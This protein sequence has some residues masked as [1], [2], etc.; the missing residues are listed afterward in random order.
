MQDLQILLQS[1][2][3]WLL[4][5][6]VLVEQAGLLSKVCKLSL[7]EDSCI[8]Q[9]QKLFL[10]I[11]ARAAG[12]QVPARRG[13]SQHLGAGGRL[14]RLGARGAEFR[15]ITNSTELV[16]RILVLGAGG[17]GGFFGGRAAQA[18]VDV[19]FLL[20]PARAELVRAAGLRIKTGDQVETV[21]PKVV[22]AD[23]PGG[24]YDVVIL[25]CK[26]YDL[27][28]AIESLKPVVGK[29]T[30]ILPILN[31]MRHYDMLDRAFGKERVLGGLCQVT[32]TIGPEGEILVMG[33][34]STIIFGEREGG[35]SPRGGAIQK[36]LAPA[37][38]TTKC[39]DDIF[40][41][42][43]EKYVFL[44]ALA[45]AT[46]LMRGNVGE[47]ARTDDGEHFMRSL[48]METNSVARGHGHGMRPNAEA[49]AIKAL[50][51]ASS[52]VT[53]SMFRDLRQGHRIEG[54][55]LIGDM[56]HRAGELGLAVPCLRTAYTHLQV[57][58]AQRAA[59]QA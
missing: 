8:R 16:M 43:W 23:A 41:D 26:A 5:L 21:H 54:E 45:A 57:Y 39:S 51:D 28:S 46:C 42:I 34:F 30:V 49:F 35:I 50:T 37:A 7:S 52:S 53:A 4:F 14:R 29:D 32:A 33:P 2:G 19:T 6:N 47:I 20:R 25:S 40:Q 13:L 9:T 27:D 17:T 56:V 22:T 18:G 36:A 15:T 48:L 31:G 24:P 12:M 3:S 44:A 58:E 10:Q 59:R 1:Y 55:H 11:G 38:F